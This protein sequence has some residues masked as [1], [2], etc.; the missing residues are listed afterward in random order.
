MEDTIWAVAM[1]TAPATVTL[2]TGAQ[3]QTFDVPAGVS[4]LS[5]PIAAGGSMHGSIVRS[6][7]TV[8]DLQPQGFSFNGSP[9]TYNYNAFVAYGG[10]G[11]S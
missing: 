5:L 7:Q 3:T 1:T 2:S 6:G 10:A 11:G 9:A 8:V 4:K